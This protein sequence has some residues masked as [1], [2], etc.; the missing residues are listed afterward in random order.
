MDKYVNA[1]AHSNLHEAFT[2]LYAFVIWN[3][4]DPKRTFFWLRNEV[5][6]YLKNM[7]LPAED[8]KSEDVRSVAR[9]SIAGFFGDVGTFSRVKTN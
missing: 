3:E 5:A 6:S 8:E 4:S 9:E 7:T 1:Y 2:A